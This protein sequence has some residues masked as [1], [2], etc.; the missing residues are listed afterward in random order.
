MPT[1][2]EKADVLVAL[3][4]REGAFV[5]PNPWDVGS[6]RLLAA[7]G[8]EAL[9]TTSAGNAWAR[10]V[11]DGE[12]G[13]EAALAHARELAEATDLPVSVDFENGFAERPEAVAEHVARLAETGVAGGSIEDF[14][15]A[16]NG[17]IYDF[18]LAVERVQAAVETAHALDRPFTLTAR[19]E[20]LLH[21]VDDFDDTVRRLQAFERAGAD[22]LYAPGLRTLEQVRALTAAVGKPVN[23]LAPMVA[24]A[25]MDELA[26]AG[27]KRLSIG[28]ALAGVAFGAALRAAKE[29]SSGSF[30]GLAGGADRGEL[31]RLL[32]AATPD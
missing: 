12:L 1:P 5:I 2:R 27:A 28:G 20:N 10:G 8:F 7:L 11:Q 24:D 13:L 22:V 23:V 18:E 29:L 32:H 25:T 14:T 15:G 9:A 21:G 26:A 17:P 30:G 4:Q 6:A 3:H 19:S 16:D 31:G